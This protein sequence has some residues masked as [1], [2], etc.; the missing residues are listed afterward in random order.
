MN[1]SYCWMNGWKDYKSSATVT[2]LPTT[3]LKSGARIPGMVSCTFRFRIFMNGSE[4]INGWKA[5][6]SI[7]H[8]SGMFITDLDSQ[9]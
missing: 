9:N 2:A 3:W 4:W 6:Y 1:E 7:L 8:V 5:V